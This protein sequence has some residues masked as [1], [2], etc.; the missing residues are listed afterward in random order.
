MR[1][2]RVILIVITLLA[3]AVSA[4][5]M[6]LSSPLN[7]RSG[8]TM[9]NMAPMTNIFPQPFMIAGEYG[10][11]ACPPSMGSLFTSPVFIDNPITSKSPETNDIQRVGNIELTNGF[12]GLQLNP[13]LNLLPSGTLI[14][15]GSPTNQLSQ[16]SLIQ[17]SKGPFGT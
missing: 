17:S 15:S 8:I 14:G 9:G 16:R 10:E 13:S 6:P 4:N 5:A 12:N 2:S 1:V 3:I 7:S 11:Y